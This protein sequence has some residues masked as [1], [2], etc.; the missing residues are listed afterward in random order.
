M[1]IDWWTTG[2]QILVSVLVRPFS[3][4][5]Y[6]SPSD[7]AALSQT[8]TSRHTDCKVILKYKWEDYQKSLVNGH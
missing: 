6:L 7:V 5:S 1:N 2:N 4:G 8:S 3:F